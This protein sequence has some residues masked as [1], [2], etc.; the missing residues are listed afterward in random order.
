M[1]AP[2]DSG[3]PGAAC[4]RP[5]AS[6]GPARRSSRGRDRRARASGP[7]GN[8]RPDGATRSCQTRPN[9]R[10]NRDLGRHPRRPYLATTAL[11]RPLDPDRYTS[12][13]TRAVL[14][15]FVPDA[16][17][18]RRDQI[19]GAEPGPSHPWPPFGK[20]SQVARDMRAGSRVIA[21]SS[22]SFSDGFIYPRVLRVCR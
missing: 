13:S 8:A 11:V 5:R 3:S 21:T 10:R 20:R 7:R 22:A 4:S 18:P 19:H 17:Q 9:P 1:T 15:T 16:A 6:S 14:P 12:G 2:R